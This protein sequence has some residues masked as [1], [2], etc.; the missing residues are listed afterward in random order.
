M[1]VIPAIDVLDGKVVRLRQGRFEDVTVYA[2]DAVSLACRY[3]E[4]GARMIHVVDLGAARDGGDHA[5]SQ[6]CAGLASA[7]VPFQLGGGIRSAEVASL[8]VEFGASRVVV[9]SAAVS[10]PEGLERIVGAVGA[11]RVVAA[12]DV[13][14][15]RA[16]G[17][18]WEDDGAPMAEVLDRVVSVGVPWAL[19]TGIARDGTLDGPDLDLLSVVREGWPGL[20]LIASGG[21]GSLDDLRALASSGHDAVVVG[22]AL[23]DGMF[24]L[25]EAVAA[26]G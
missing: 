15:G 16:R 26:A 13:R 23:L 18:G 24:T 11:D 4:E 2:D 5:R 25:A 3:A 21:V 8:I 7:G 1:Q 20:Q 10:D 22:R 17:A 14:D 9:G 19:V 6:L 12:V